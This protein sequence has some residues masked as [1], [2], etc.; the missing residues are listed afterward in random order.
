MTHSEQT[1]RTAAIMAVL[2]LLDES[3]SLEAVGRNAGTVWAQEHR[4]LASGQSSLLYRRS[5]RSPWR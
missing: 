4:L 1:L 2:S 5:A 3:S